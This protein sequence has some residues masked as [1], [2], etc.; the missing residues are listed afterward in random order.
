VVATVWIGFDQPK[1]LYEYGAQAA[2]PAWIDF[3]REALKDK[4]EHTLERP[5]SIVS[6]RIDPYSGNRA[7]PEQRNAIFELFA[8]GT[9]PNFSSPNPMMQD[10]EGEYSYGYASPDN[11]SATLF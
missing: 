5:N 7:Y 6:V 9:E 4:P 2:L 3:M 8:D 11:S 10:E 1:S